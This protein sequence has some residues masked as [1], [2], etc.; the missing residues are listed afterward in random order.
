[1]TKGSTRSE[2][3]WTRATHETKMMETSQNSIRDWQARARKT[4]ET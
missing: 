4:P 1:M 3:R 2:K